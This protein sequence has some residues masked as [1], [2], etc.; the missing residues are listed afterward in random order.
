M[1]LAIILVGQIL[2]VTFGGAMFEVVPLSLGDWV[3]IILGTSVI[4]WAGE[5]GRLKVKG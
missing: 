1:T 4:L 3:R 2:I 5:L